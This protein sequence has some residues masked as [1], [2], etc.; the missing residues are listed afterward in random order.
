MLAGLAAATLLLCAGAARA[1]E[2]GASGSGAGSRG[3]PPRDLHLSAGAGALLGLSGV[4]PYADL[5]LTFRTGLLEVGGFVQGAYEFSGYELLGAG[6][7]AGVGWRAPSGLRISLAAA[8][9]AH[10]YERFGYGTDVDDPGTD[11]TTLFAGGRGG[12][13]WIFGRGP[14]HFELGL[15][16]TY[17]IDLLRPRKLYPAPH[18]RYQRSIIRDVGNTHVTVSLLRLGVTFDMP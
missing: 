1:Q 12:A 14:V 2:G 4:G 11:G 9:G 10:D 13:S 8:V 6:A 16:V 7:T 17:E 3:I 18:P 15:A 5:A